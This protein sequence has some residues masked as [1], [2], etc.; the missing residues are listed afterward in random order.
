MEWSP[1]TITGRRPAPTIAATPSVILSR[2]AVMSAGA[3]STSPQS[4]M[5][6]P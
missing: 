2:F 6:T 5:V 3:I 4:A 1:P